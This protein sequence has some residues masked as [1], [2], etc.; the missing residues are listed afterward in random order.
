VERGLEEKRCAVAGERRRTEE[1]REFKEE[2]V[3]V[4]RSTSNGFHWGLFKNN[5]FK[6]KK[7]K[8]K[9]N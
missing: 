5:K 1:R 4:M 7:I 6:F 3:A 8:N 9:K 2:S